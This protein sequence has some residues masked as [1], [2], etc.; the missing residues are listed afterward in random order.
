MFSFEDAYAAKFYFDRYRRENNVWFHWH[1]NILEAVVKN[2][3]IAQQTQKFSSTKKISSILDLGCGSGHVARFLA[4]THRTKVIG[5]DL[6]VNTKIKSLNFKFNLK[7]LIKNYNCRTTMIKS[8]HKNFLSKNKR[9]FDLIIDNCSVTHFDTSACGKSNSGW[10]YM[11][12]NLKHHL[13][14]DGAF[15]TATDVSAGSFSNEFCSEEGIKETFQDFDWEVKNQDQ[16]VRPDQYME[17]S[18][19][20]SEF[21]NKRFL[22]VPPPNTLDKGALGISGMVFRI[23]NK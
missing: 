12:K 17:I 4:K 21:S 20:F 3:Y 1:Y 18:K 5:F 14:M 7:S 11:A 15:I 16:I 23:K 22:R 6:G 10:N 19:W 2:A 9:K 8:D 13:N